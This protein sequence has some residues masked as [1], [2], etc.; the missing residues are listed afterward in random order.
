M[1][2]ITTTFTLLHPFLFCTFF[3]FLRQGLATSAQAG[4]ELVILLPLS[5]KYLELQA[6]TTMPTFWLLF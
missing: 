6:Y 4:L 3:F 1:Y 5:P 2:N